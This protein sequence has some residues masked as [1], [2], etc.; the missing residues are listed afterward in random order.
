[1]DMEVLIKLTICFDSSIWFSGIDHFMFSIVEGRGQEG[2]YLQE[3][4]K[5]ICNV[6]PYSPV[7]V[8]NLA[9]P[10]LVKQFIMGLSSW[11][12]LYCPNQCNLG[13]Y[14]HLF[15][16]RNTMVLLKLTNTQ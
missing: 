6:P 8:A 14:L 7:R 12:R 4:I 5:K 15:S 11:L 1:M 9:D 3:G 16:R 13:V 10:D 2:N